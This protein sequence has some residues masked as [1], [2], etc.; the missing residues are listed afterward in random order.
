MSTEFPARYRG[1][2]NECGAWFPAD[3][4]IRYDDAGN[5]VHAQPD[6]CVTVTEYE[7]AAN[8][9]RCPSCFCYHAGECA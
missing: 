2:C 6:E 5:I 7:A 9:T 3:T 8:E 1:E 4:M